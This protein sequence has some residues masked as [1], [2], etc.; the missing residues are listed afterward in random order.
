VRD[1]G[2]VEIVIRGHNLPGRRFWNEGEPLENVHVGVQVRGDPVGLVAGDAASAEWRV[3]VRAETAEGR[4]DFKGPAVHG[5]R[6][7]RFLYLTWG[8]VD[9]DG[10]FTMFR[11]A[12]LMLDQVEPALVRDALARQRPL[13]A[14]IDLTDARG[15]PR[16]A[17]V[18]RP[19]LSWTV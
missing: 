6:G 4:L 8:D 18:D 7:Q 2:L 5:P 16:C 19:A 17:R 10:A 9:D 15:G 12:K 3:D 11:R 14:T 1:D 13:H